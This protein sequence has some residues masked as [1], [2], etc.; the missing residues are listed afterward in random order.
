M[1]CYDFMRRFLNSCC[2]SVA[3]LGW[4]RNDLL[5]TVCLRSVSDF[6]GCGDDRSSMLYCENNCG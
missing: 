2:F 3:L 6:D 5:G 4:N 1:Q